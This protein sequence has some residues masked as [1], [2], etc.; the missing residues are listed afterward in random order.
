MSVQARSGTSNLGK[1]SGYA[2]GGVG[3]T[4]DLVS[5]KDARV[6]ATVTPTRILAKKWG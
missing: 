2:G 3:R 5:P 4:Y 6:K 1:D